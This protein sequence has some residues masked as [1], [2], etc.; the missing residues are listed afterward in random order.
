[1]LEAGDHKRR[2]GDGDAALARFL[3]VVQKAR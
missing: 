2:N 1:M 3:E